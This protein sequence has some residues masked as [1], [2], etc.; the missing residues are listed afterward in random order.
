MLELPE[1]ENRILD[2]TNDNVSGANSIAKKASECLDKFAGEVLENFPEMA[3]EN[4]FVKL[5]KIGKRLC[6]AQITMAPVLTAVNNII[7][8]VKSSLPNINSEVGSDKEKQLQY[9]CIL[10][11]MTAR[12]YNLESQLSLETIARRYSEVIQDNDT[13]MTISASSI[14]EKLILEAHNDGLAISV[15]TP[16]SR[17][18]I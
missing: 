2:I 4:F 3:P 18:N 17:P 11:Q 14:V 12:K 6:E 1:I 10:T 9:I 7:L 8:E 5:L 15:Y 13:I 16:E